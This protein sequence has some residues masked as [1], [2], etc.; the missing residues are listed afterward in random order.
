VVRPDGSIRWI[1]N[2]GFPIRDESGHFYRLAGIAE[3][4]TERKQA[5]EKL[6]HSES[7]LAEAQRVAHVGYWENSID[8]GEIT[9]SDETYRI[10]GLQPQQPI[11]NFEALIHPEDRPVQVEATARMLRGE[12]SDVEYRVVRPNGEVR[13]VHSQGEAIRDEAGR[14]R[15]TFGTVQDVTELKRTQETLKASSEQLRALAARLQNVREEGRTR[16]AREIHDELG[17]ALTAIKIELSSLIRGLPADKEQRS[18]SILKLVDET[19]Q[20]VRRIA[21]ELRPGILDDLGLVAA[22]EWAAQEFETRTGTKC[23]FD[24]PKDEDDIAI[25]RE[26]AT[27]IFRIFQETLTNVAR[28]AGASQVDVQL[29]RQDGNIVFEV[30]DNGKGIDQRDLESHS[31]LGI[32]GMRERVLLLGGEFKI[33]G[34]PGNGTTVTVRISER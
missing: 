28:H 12:H 7:Q 17:Q 34:S 27:T 30:R 25:D 11:E 2:R 10:F 13:I 23:R 5:R 16:V 29:T 1:W 33:A 32:L 8:A 3:D 15:R 4:I 18:G 21:T 14:P 6:K 9:W 24:V 31:S 22:V 19:I 26:R 20:S